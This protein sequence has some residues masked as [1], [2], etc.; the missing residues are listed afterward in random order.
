MPITGSAPADIRLRFATMKVG[1]R[2]RAAMGALGDELRRSGPGGWA[3]PLM[4]GEPVE[5]VGLEA[6]LGAAPLDDLVDAG[7]AA[8]PGDRFVLATTISDFGGV[9]TAIP[10]HPWGDETVYV[11]PDSAHLIEAALRLAPKGERAADLGTG[12]GL[13]AAVLTTRYRAVVATD[14][15]LSVVGAADLTLALNRRPPGHAAA[16]CVA[17][18]GAGL[19]PDSFDLVVA[20][21][22][23]VPLAVDHTAPQ[24]LFAHGGEFGVELP[25]RFVTEGAALLRPGGVAITLALDMELEGHRRPLRSVCDRLAEAGFVTVTLP[26]PFNRERPHLLEL[27]QERQPALTAATHV[28]VV[29]ARPHGGD[30]RRRSLRV[31]ADALRRR[32]QG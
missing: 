4:R 31:A 24:E 22:P 28:A 29:A 21:A 3:A 25:A 27:M 9:L 10:K 11:G 16:A 23:W 30:P 14:L 20:N 12:T 2:G 26:T 8:H 32:W 1:D 13:L 7:L 6:R 5:W 18:V 19:R 17:D 15:A